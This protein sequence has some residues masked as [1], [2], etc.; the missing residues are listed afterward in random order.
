MQSLSHLKH[1][2]LEW[3]PSLYFAMGLPFV[4]LN[5]VSAV[6]YKDLG[7]SDA[8]IAFWTSLIMWPWTIKFLWSPFLELYRTKKFWVVGSQLLSGVLFGVAA[9]SL[10]LPLF[11]SVSVAVFAVVAFS[12]ATHDIAADGVYMSELSPAS[13]AKYIGWQGAFYN[14]AKLVATGGLVWFA[15]WLYEGFSA[16]GAS[17]YDASVGSW[18]VV[19]LLLCVTLVALG[20]YHLRALPS[21]GSASEG[22][23]LRDGLSGLREVIGA[24]FTKRHI[25][26]YIAFIILYRL[27]EGFVMKIVPL[28]LNAPL[29]NQGLGLTEQQIGLYYGTFGVI[30]FVVGSILGGYFIAWLKLRRALFPLITIFNIPFV[31][32][33]LLAWFQPASPL[34]ICGGIVFEYFSYGF[35]FV[36][37][38]LF[39]MQQVAPGPHKMAH[40]AF[41]SSLANLGVMLLGM[42]SG[43][44]C[45]QVGYHR[46]FLWALM[47]TIPIF[48]IA[49]RI[50]FAHP[51]TEE[52]A[53]H[54]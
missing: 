50:P 46:F 54:R 48:L 17:S 11:F 20:L 47:A 35:G 30:A 15:G 2:P 28:F 25:W 9:L 51:D 45:D 40:Y 41:G 53:A 36:G 5:M 8:Q 7:I 49:W 26:Y 27:G 13:Q 18:T 31:V 6:L 37:L 1:S 34:L 29:D 32:Y 4:V 19:L 23:S 21:G 43:W 3:V 38:T 39:I 24:F 22:R 52:G 33:A 14:L 42:A 10:Q 16:D 44:L 12:G